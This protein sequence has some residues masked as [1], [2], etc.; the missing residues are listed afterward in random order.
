MAVIIAGTVYYLAAVMPYQRVFL[1]VGKENVK[2]GYFL[3]RVVASSGGD[4]S[5]TVQQL[6]A[7]LVI[8][9]AAPQYGLRSGNCPGY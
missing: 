4:P 3:K 8:D 7:E 6:A 2:M 1:T 9:Q 5:T